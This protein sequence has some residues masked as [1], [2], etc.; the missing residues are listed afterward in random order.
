MPGDG[1]AFGGR[2]RR[3]RDSRELSQRELARLLRMSYGT[4]GMYETGK[5][6]PDF[7]TL[8]T[9]AE[10]F[11]VTVDYLLGRTD[12]PRGKAPVSFE[13]LGSGWEDR[14]DRILMDQGLSDEERAMIIDLVRL[15]AKKRGT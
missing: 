7:S 3:L 1:A 6:E 15:R 9:I 4:I 14:M 5:R 12:D 2:L 13:E 8:L 11:G 10:Y